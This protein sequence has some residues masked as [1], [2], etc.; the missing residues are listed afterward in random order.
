MIHPSIQKVSE[1]SQNYPSQ[2]PRIPGDVFK[3]LVIFPPNAPNIK[4]INFIIFVK[5][6]IAAIL[7]FEK[8]E[9]GFML[10]ESGK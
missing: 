7:T 10:D 6:E 1:N 5:H 8:V 9:Q 2:F 4:D 3:L